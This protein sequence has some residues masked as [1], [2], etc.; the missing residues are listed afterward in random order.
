MTD[1]V[2]IMGGVQTTQAFLFGLTIG[3]FIIAIGTYSLY[4]LRTWGEKDERKR[5][6]DTQTKDARVGQEEE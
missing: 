5:E 2:Y 6:N 1:P 4:A 3:G